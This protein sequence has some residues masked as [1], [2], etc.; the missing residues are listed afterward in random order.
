MIALARYSVSR[1]QTRNGRSK[2][3]PG[4]LL[5]EELGAEALGLRSEVHHQLGTHD[6]VGE[7]GE[8]LDL[9]GQHQLTTRLIARGRRLALDHQRGEVGTGGV[10]R[11]GEPG[12]AGADDDDVA[13][14]LGGHG[15]SSA[16]GRI[17]GWPAS[18]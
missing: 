8:V 11:C 18:S 16:G 13:D 7:A 5:G 9:G 15:H 10:D 17:S 12:R 4:D 1:T 2:I 6:A 3:D 14:G